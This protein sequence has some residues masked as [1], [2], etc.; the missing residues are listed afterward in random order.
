MSHFHF[1][2]CKCISYLKETSS[3]LY[4][5]HSRL[6]LSIIKQRLPQHG[7]P[8]SQYP[9]REVSDFRVSLDSDSKTVSLRLSVEQLACIIQL[10][11]PV[12][13]CKS[14]QLSRLVCRFCIKTFKRHRFCFNFMKTCKSRQLSRLCAVSIKKTFKRRRLI[15]SQ[16]AK[17]NSLPFL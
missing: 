13:P 5:Y 8:A 17:I 10:S 9:K 15:H 7:R 14:R 12:K 3:P 16:N 1:R 11:S 2:V 6:L 4:I